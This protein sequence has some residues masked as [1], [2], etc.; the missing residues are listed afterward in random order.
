MDSYGNWSLPY[1]EEIFHTLLDLDPI[2]DKDNPAETSSEAL[3]SYT[4][5]FNGDVSFDESNFRAGNKS[6]KMMFSGDETHSITLDKL[7]L[8]NNVKISFW[9]NATDDAPLTITATGTN[10][11]NEVFSISKIHYP[12]IDQWQKITSA[13]N[14]SYVNNLTISVN[15]EDLTL[16]IDDI[17]VNSYK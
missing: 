7:F 4:I 12:K 13:T 11:G 6:L 5:D 17:E 3:N 1:T 8:D 15:A 10:E 9:I 14:T 2:D 16:W